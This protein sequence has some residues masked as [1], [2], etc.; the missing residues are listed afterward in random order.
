MIAAV[1]RNQKASSCAQQSSSVVK[2]MHT[3]RGEEQ[4]GGGGE[5][6][7]EPHDECKCRGAGGIHVTKTSEKRRALSTRLFLS[8]SACLFCHS[9]HAGGNKH[10]GANKHFT[11]ACEDDL[12]ERPY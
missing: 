9:P 3:C 6:A 11:D 1:R 5:M 4:S 7:T 12:H 8:R 2:G 10:F